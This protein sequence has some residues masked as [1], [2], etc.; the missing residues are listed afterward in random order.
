M[1]EVSKKVLRIFFILLIISSSQKCLGQNRKISGKVLDS[2]SFEEIPYVNISVV[3]TLLG[4]MSDITGEFTLSVPVNSKYTV[5]FSCLG[6]QSQEVAIYSDT[7]F[8]VLLKPTSVEVKEITITPDE[9]AYS[10][11]KKVVRNKPIY[12]L[13]NCTSQE[14]ELYTKGLVIF[15][16]FNYKKDSSLNTRLFKKEFEQFAVVSEDDNVPGIPGYM[17]E[18]LSKVYTLK[19]PERERRDMLSLNIEGTIF[20]QTEMLDELIN[21]QLQINLYNNQVQLFNRTFISPLANSGKMFYKYA[22]SDTVLVAGER[23]LEIHFFPKQKENLCFSGTLWIS[24]STFIP[25]RISAHTSIKTDINFIEN[26]HIYQD[27]EQINNISVPTELRIGITALNLLVNVLSVKDKYILSEP[28]PTS[29]YTEKLTSDRLKTNKFS[30]EEKRQKYFSDFDNLALTNLNDLS[31]NTKIKA[32]SKLIE[33]S[34]TGYYKTSN[35]D[36]GP[37]ILGYSHNP[38]EGNRF[39]LG[40]NTTAN[41]SPRFNIDGYMAY[42]I[43]DDKLKGSI[44]TQFFFDKNRWGLVGFRYGSDLVNIGTQNPFEQLDAFF[45]LTSAIKG[46]LYVNH[47]NLKSVYEQIDVFQRFTIKASF[48]VSDYKPAGDDFV[49]AFYA[50]DAKTEIATDYRSTEIKGSLLFHPGNNYVVDG[51]RR[52]LTSNNS[53]PLVELSFTKGIKNLFGGNFGYHKI[54]LSLKQKILTSG[55]GYF[56]YLTS[57]EQTFGQA[58]YPLLNVLEGNESTWRS[59]SAFNLV[60]NGTIVADQLLLAR[61]EWHFDGSIARKI[62]LIKFLNIRLLTGVNIAVGRFNE[63]RNGH[64]DADNNPGG[65]LSFTNPS[66]LPTSAFQPLRKGQPYSEMYWGIENIFKIFRLDFI[67]RANSYYKDYSSEF[68][69]KISGRFGF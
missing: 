47:V 39:R 63:S 69:L 24:E 1:V 10:I 51:N 48:T 66:G 59:S 68:G 31:N 29:F 50:D 67:Y 22:L 56:N 12:A 40:G 8:T 5:G 57:Y 19:F 3:G 34:I 61:A 7:T 58:V 60:D 65:I 11:I 4:T 36:I 25:K 2:K 46:G 26:I 18:S 49:F 27:F 14:Y 52:F 37:W 23:C 17:I 15:R 9:T 35:F 30:L 55:F 6:Y 41:L 38:I 28:K 44:N 64:Y 45:A 43:K 13:E 33:M 42:G 54:N 20:N 62:P 16:K 32:F 21:N 53:F